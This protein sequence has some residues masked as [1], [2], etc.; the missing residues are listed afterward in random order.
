M[1]T[2][3]WTC[4]FQSSSKE[5]FQLSDV[6]LLLFPFQDDIA[7]EVEPKAGTSAN[8]AT[9]TPLPEAAEENVSKVNIVFFVLK[10]YFETTLS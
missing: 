1:L 6:A 5:T 2:N 8:V 10:T 9:E 4:S 7:V 3:R